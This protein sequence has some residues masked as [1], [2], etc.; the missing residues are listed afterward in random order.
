MAKPSLALS[1]AQRNVAYRGSMSRIV[2]GFARLGAARRHRSVHPFS[3]RCWHAPLVCGTSFDASDRL[4]FGLPPLHTRKQLPYRQLPGDRNA[5]PAHTWPP[6]H[7]QVPSN[8]HVK[9]IVLSSIATSATRLLRTCCGPPKS[10]IRAVGDAR[11]Q[12]MSSPFECKQGY[13]ISRE[14]AGSTVLITGACGSLSGPDSSCCH[15]PPHPPC[16]MHTVH[17][18]GEHLLHNL[19]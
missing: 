13:S 7:F 8:S 4:A 5:K 18:E 6:W 16:I 19:Q 15:P 3:W 11:A 9:S 1:A 14:F 12:K 17:G 10:L 2:V